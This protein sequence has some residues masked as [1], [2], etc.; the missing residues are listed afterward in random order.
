MITCRCTEVILLMEEILYQLV[1]DFLHQLY[2]RA[3]LTP[4]LNGGTLLGILLRPFLEPVLHNSPNYPEEY[5]HLAPPLLRISRS[6]WDWWWTRKPGNVISI[7][8]FL[9]IVLSHRILFTFHYHI[10][11]YL[12]LFDLILSALTSTYSLLFSSLPISSHLLSSVF[13][14]IIFPLL[15]RSKMPGISSHLSSFAWMGRKIQWTLEYV[16]PFLNVSE[17]WMVIDTVICF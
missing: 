2:C 11:P 17:P 13:F 1:Q 10:L 5:G 7:T 15:L 9:N 16:F 14:R 12:I 8:F 4:E 3:I 6:Y